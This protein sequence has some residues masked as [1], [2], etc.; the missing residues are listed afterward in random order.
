M[1]NQAFRMFAALWRTYGGTLVL[2]GIVGVPL[3]RGV[4]EPFARHSRESA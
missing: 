4:I 1:V 2:G 3:C